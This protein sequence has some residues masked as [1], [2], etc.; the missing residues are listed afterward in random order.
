METIDTSTTEGKI[1]VMQAFVDGKKIKARLRSEEKWFELDGIPSWEWV[2]YDY[3]IVEE[4]KKVWMVGGLA[5][6]DR[7]SAESRADILQRL[8]YRGF[9]VEEFVKVV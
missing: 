6:E 1:A 3:A 4:P 2:L 7:L 9:S 8:G 5:Y